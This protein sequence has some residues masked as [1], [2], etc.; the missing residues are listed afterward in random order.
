[1]AYDVCYRVP[2]SE[3]PADP[4]F[5][6]LHLASRSIAML[7]LVLSALSAVLI[8]AVSVMLMRD[9]EIP[10]RYIGQV[11]FAFL[12]PFIGYVIVSMTTWPM[13]RSA[14]TRV[15]HHA[16]PL[17][18]AIDTYTHE[19]GE[20]PA[21]FAVLV[22]KYIAA[23]PISGLAAYPTFSYTRFSTKTARR[24]LWWYDLGA[25]HGRTV[26]TNWEYPD[27]DTGH[28]LLALELDGEDRVV[29]VKADRMAE[30]PSLATFTRA[31]WDKKPIDRQEMVADL[32][33]RFPLDGRSA[34]EVKQLLGEP[35]GTRILVSSPW[36]LSLRTWPN[37]GDKF[38]Y[39]P[40]HA[41]PTV[42]DSKSVM[43][44]GTWA[45]TRD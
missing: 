37:D 16:A 18:A 35:D 43:K 25:R 36:E 27:G 12:T 45:Y 40:T 33:H 39:W 9:R 3:L 15:E 42:L 5:A 14:L 23:V 31:D 44:V 2:L 32:Q 8:V 4:A 10:G 7:L 29:S 11:G 34:D 22:P 13:H 24:V 41:Y 1:V 6:K 28:A 26:T 19:V 21:S 20:P 30:E 38:F 17:I